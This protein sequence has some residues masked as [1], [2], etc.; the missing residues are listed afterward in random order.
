[1]LS[2]KDRSLPQPLKSKEL[3]SLISVPSHCVSFGHMT[4]CKCLRLNTFGRVSR[5]EQ[6]T[7]L[8]EVR[9]SR[10]SILSGIETSLEQP[11]KVS[12]VSFDRLPTLS[13][14]DI[15]AEHQLRSSEVRF[16]I[17]PNVSGNDTRVEHQLRSS[18]VSFERFPILDGNDRS[19]EHSVRSS[20]PSLERSPIL[21]GN[22]TRFVHPLKSKERISLMFLPSH[23]ASF[24][25]ITRCMLLR[26][27]ISGSD[28]RLVQ[29]VRLREV[30]LERLPM[31]D[32]NDR[33]LEHPLKS[34]NC[35]LL[36]CES[37]EGSSVIGALMLMLS[38]AEN[39]LIV[40]G[41]TIDCAPSVFR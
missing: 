31:F 19:L 40:S 5:L 38:T 23:F 16:D 1:M 8:S 32:G 41:M 14:N 24:G 7:R 10:R 9:L 12:E 21:D 28:S 27:N 26:L 34:R 37:T 25:H 29:P 36:S 11:V 17:L 2:G 6:R 4:K 33:S 30:S 13:G 39:L 3:S 15:R 18:E 22:D 35:R 20:D